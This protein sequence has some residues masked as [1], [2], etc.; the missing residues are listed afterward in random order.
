MNTKRNPPIA[1]LGGTFNPIHNAHL[2]MAEAARRVLGPCEVLLMVDRDPPHK[3]IAGDVTAAQRFRM[4][5]LAVMGMDGITAS[6]ME[7][8]REGKSYTVDTL[9]AL[10]KERPGAQLRLIVGGDMLADLPTWREAGEICRLAKII[11]VPR[12]GRGGAEAA[13]AARV[14]EALGADVTVLDTPA[15]DISSTMIRE[16]VRAAK[17]IGDLTPPAVT[18]YIY[19]EGLYFP[20]ELRNM[21]ARLRESLSPTRF[22]HTMG[23]VK[24]AVDLAARHGADGER[25]RLSALLH[26]CGRAVDKGALTHAAASERLAREQFGVTDEVVLTAIRLHTTGGP[27]MDRLARILYLADMIEP[28]RAYPGVEELR[29]LANENL[30]A[31]VIG[32][33]EQTL[34]YVESRGLTADENTLAALAALKNEK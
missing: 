31:A 13:D 23:V 7:L 6:D 29:A 12:P 16:R 26:D 22:A 2:F 24:T 18:A 10:L 28:N 32:G 4:A 33:M 17:P 1:M 21:Q 20:S 9:R 34:R 25:A 5:E 11:A 3:Q 15:P 27:R 19:E 14:R 30:T 8:K